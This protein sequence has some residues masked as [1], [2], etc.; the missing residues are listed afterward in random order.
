MSRVDGQIP[1]SSSSLIFDMA[2]RR[3]QQSSESFDFEN[4]IKYLIAKSKFWK[5]NCK[6]HFVV[7]CARS[8]RCRVLCSSVREPVHDWIL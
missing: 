1:L 5:H 8:S 7:D 2:E 6:K 4:T 3:S